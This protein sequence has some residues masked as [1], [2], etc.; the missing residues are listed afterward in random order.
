MLVWHSPLFLQLMLSRHSGH[1]F[2]LDLS[3]HCSLSDKE[4]FPRIIVWNF[5]NTSVHVHL[6]I[7]DHFCPQ[8]FD[9]IRLALWGIKEGENAANFSQEHFGS[10]WF[11]NLGFTWQHAVHV[12]PQNIDLIRLALWGIQEGKIAA[13]FYQENVGSIRSINFGFTMLS[14]FPKKFWSY[15]TCALGD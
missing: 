11:I 10:I 4:Y 1:C 7:S 8:H 12:C 3:H 5:V 9:L 2:R 14:I 15:A 13:N 6:G